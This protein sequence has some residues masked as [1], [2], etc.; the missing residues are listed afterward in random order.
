MDIFE[1]LPQLII[2]YDSNDKF[3]NL[4]H[5]QKSDKEK[6]YYCPCCG[7]IVNP[8]ALDSN[9]EQSHYYHVTGKCTKESQLHFFCKNWLFEKGSKF[10]INNELYEVKTVDIEKTYSTPFGD[11]R[12][13]VTVCTTSGKTIYFEMF[14]TNRKTG[15]DYFCKWSYL[16]NDVVEVNIKEYMTK[17][18]TNTIPLF[19]YL[20]HDGVCFSKSYIKKDLYANTIDKIKHELMHQDILDYKARIERLDWFW[21]KIITN[22][23]KESILEVISLMNYEDMVSCYNIIK[24]KHCV[25]Y[26]KNDVLNIINQKVVS[27]V[28]ETLDL[29]YD[30]NIYF[31]LRHVRGRTY[32]AGIRLN[33]KTNHITY[34]KLF[35]SCNNYWY[36]FDK[37][38][39][40]PKIVFDKNIFSID[41]LVISEKNKQELLKIYEYVLRYREKLVYYEKDLSSYEQD[42]YK[43]KM[44]DD[45]YTVLVKK[46]KKFD[47]LFENLYIKE[48]DVDELSREINRKLTNNENDLF[49]KELFVSDEYN[50][51]LSSFKN[52]KNL[53]ICL[54]IAKYIGHTKNGVRFKMYICGR[55]IYDEELKTTMDDFLNKRDECKSLIDSFIKSYAIILDFVNQINC[56]KNKFWKADF[57]FDYNG[58]PIVELDQ[59]HFIPRKYLTL[60][61]VRFTEADLLSKQD[62]ADKLKIGMF[63]VFK[64]M[65]TCGYR[66][67]EVCD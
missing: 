36:D 25:S 22:E 45:L 29:P 58:Y 41:E 21:Q 44:K 60:S 4:I 18:E 6:T 43:I 23:S 37:L 59:K 62:I 19:T 66:V 13:D 65:E 57:S 30:E 38:K 46:D 51:F 33:I 9:K 53:D 48:F 67:M 5:V 24:R 2:A 8:R 42:T 14:F 17:T 39:D 64:N 61:K 34:N 16:E 20:F 15:D 54:D 35:A 52:H 32:E 28:R 26:L 1:Y 49:L 27:D 12:P 56:C 31:D 40:F 10:Y 3:A 11:Y 7:G 55:R 63:E 50:S 47:L